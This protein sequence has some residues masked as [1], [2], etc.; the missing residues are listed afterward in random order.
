[1]DE[2]DTETHAQDGTVSAPTG[3]RRA[4]LP[5]GPRL[6]ALALVVAVLA[7]AG[8]W[9]A[10]QSMSGATKAGD[11]VRRT[12]LTS[13]TDRMPTLAVGRSAVWY[14]GW[15]EGQTTADEPTPTWMDAVVRLPEG[16]AGDL[17]SAYNT[18]PAS[19]RPEVVGELEEDV[20]LGELR[21]SEALDRALSTEYWHA[22]AYLSVA[23]DT[24]V[25]VV[26]GRT[27]TP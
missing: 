18:V 17:A 11:G 23:S 2:T 27:E 24:L 14:S 7:A 15:M 13:L 21:T 3:R 6:L 9:T 5:A 22:T 16:R 4:T 8:V 20:P 12:D 1:M 26:E 25:L 19:D 10:A